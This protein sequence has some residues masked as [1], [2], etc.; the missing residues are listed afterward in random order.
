MNVACTGSTE[1][2]AASVDGVLLAL[3]VG[4]YVSDAEAAA[5]WDVRL[6]GDEP[7][8]VPNDTEALR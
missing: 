8:F 6:L 4:I 1:C 7:S 2:R 5:K 3:L